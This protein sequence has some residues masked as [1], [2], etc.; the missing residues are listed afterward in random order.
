MELPFGFKPPRTGNYVLKLKKNLY[1]LKDA[2][3]NWFKYL[4][5]G[6]ESKKLQFNKSEIDQCVFLRNDCIVLVYMD[7]VILISR[8]SST[9]DKVINVLKSKDYILEDE[10][11]LDKQL[12]VNI[13]KHDD[14][15]F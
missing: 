2:A 7:D 15:S 12:G 4:S 8:D 3:T 11:D 6:L 13:V 14:G 10:G 5:D 9:T 1:G